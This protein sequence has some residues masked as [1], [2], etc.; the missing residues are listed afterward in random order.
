[1]RQAWAVCKRELGAYFHTPAA[2]VVLAVFLALSG[3][4]FAAF[5]LLAPAADL[6]PVLGNMAVIF[7]FLAPA[8]T[9]RLWAEEQRSGTDELL[10]TAPM[11][12]SHL[13]LGKYAAAL[14]LLGACLALTWP[15]PA[16]LD[17]YGDLDWSATLAG[18]LGLALLGAAALAA[19]LFASS[20]TDSQ[21][22]AGVL[23]FGILLLFWLAGWVGDHVPGLTGRVLQY[24]ALTQHYPDFGQGV[25]D[26]GHVTYFV[27]LAGSFLF[28]TMQRLAAARNR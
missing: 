11:S 26:L 3:T 7:L 28:L 8:L 1:M 23:G 2:Y 19:G 13:V 6:G 12:V 25:V 17:L 9:A 4:L 24:L 27:T 18:Y 10:L 20:L 16:L 22:V 21:V 14:G 5:V 15:F